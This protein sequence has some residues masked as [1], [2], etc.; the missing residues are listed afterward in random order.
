[1]NIFKKDAMFFVSLLWLTFP[2]YYSYAGGKIV[3]FFATI[4]MGTFYI[5]CLYTDNDIL[6]KFIFVYMC[7]Y[8]VYTVSFYNAGNIMSILYISSLINYRFEDTNFKSFKNI[9][10]YITIVCSIGTLVFG[11]HLSNFEKVAGFTLATVCIFM[12]IATSRMIIR[13]QQEHQK[14][15][16]HKYINALLA[17]NE[18][19]R[20]GRDLHDTLGHVFALLS[21]K[22]ELAIKL[23]EKEKYELLKTELTELNEITKKSMAEV[24]EVIT[25]L[26]Y[27][28][29]SEEL[30]QIRET[31]ALANI[32]L[33]INGEE[34]VANINPTLQSTISMII[35]ECA[36]NVIKHS[37]ANKV[38]INFN[39]LEKEIIVYFE[40]NGVGFAENDDS[41]LTSIKERLIIVNGKLEIISRSNPTTI[42]V[43]LPLERV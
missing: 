42:K 32:S 14:M 6:I 8:I 40:D 9:S 35:R 11:E 41:E 43:V 1:M 21:L 25:N 33:E 7:G 39:H 29:I 27:R 19:N 34:K 20:I 2:L 28:T 5:T 12:H 17:E 22:S 16:E 13:E 38:T 3:A 4:L 15:A 26:K 30:T 24:R 23:L 10:F 37:K 31:L 18:R 36:N